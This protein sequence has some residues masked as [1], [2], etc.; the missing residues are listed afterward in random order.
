MENIKSTVAKLNCGNTQGTAFLISKNFA[1]TMSHCVQ[2]AIDD[3]KKIYLSFKNIYGEDE[4]ERIATILEYDN[5]FP[6]SILKIDNKIDNINPLEIK[7]FNNQLT[8]GTRVLTYGYP[9]VKGEEGSFVDLSID[10]YLHENVENDADITLKISADNRMQNYS[11]MSGSPVIYKNGIIGILTEQT[12]ELSNFENKAIALK[13]ISMKKVRKMLDAFNINYIEKDNDT[14]QSYL[15][16]NVY[17]EG[18]RKFFKEHFIIES[19]DSGGVLED[20]EKLIDNDL[21]D[22]ILIKNKGN[23]KKAWE[24]ID[25]MIA[26]V[27]GSNSKS[28]KILARLYYQKACWYID[29]Y[30]DCKNAQRYIRKVLKINKDF[31]CRNYNAKKCIIKG[32]FSE[33]KEILNPIDNVFVL[34]TYLQ[35]C[36]Y[37]ADVDDAFGAFEKNKCFANETTYYLMSLIAIL[38]EDYQL[39]HRY[40]YKSNEVN[41]DFPLHIMMEGVIKYWEILPSNMIYGGDLLPPMYVNSIILLNNEL[42]Q[43]MKEIGENLPAILTGDFNVDQTHRSYLALTESGILCDAFEVADLRYATNGTFNGFDSDNYTESRIDHVFVTPTFHILKY[44]V[45][46]D[47]YRRMKEGAQKA[48]VKDCPEEISIRSY[49]SRI[50]S[51][52]FPVMVKLEACDKN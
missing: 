41:K 32:K 19:V 14:V 46:T 40:L 10:D 9:K 51:D 4:I 15:E 3:N 18:K 24:K 2:E 23:I 37:S 35:V 22:I 8:R 1:L 11:G 49:E 6:V 17:G 39:A 31:D 30:E 50:P 38:D 45:L 33:A 48:S 16:D 12:N 44:G 25:E 29:D 7:C 5:S 20:Y 28:P 27:R 36:T 21:N 43:K 34:N 13:M 42:K 26:G 47:S 52:H